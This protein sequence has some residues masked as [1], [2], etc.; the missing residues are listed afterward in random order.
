MLS[1]SC[2][3]PEVVV[4]VAWFAFTLTGAA[5]PDAE[6]VTDENADPSAVL[7]EVTALLKVVVPP[8]WLSWVALVSAVAA[9]AAE[10]CATMVTWA[11]RRAAEEETL[12]PVC[13]AGGVA[14]LS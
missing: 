1:P 12:Q 8:A 13:H 7:A 3:A 9:F 11:E 10:T 2:E 5:M 14:E 4:V 6:T